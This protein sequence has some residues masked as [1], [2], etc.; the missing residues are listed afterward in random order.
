MPPPQT[1]II[2]TLDRQTQGWL[3]GLAVYEHPFGPEIHIICII[4]TSR[5]G[6]QGKQT[7]GM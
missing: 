3:K 1:V 7:G 6:C 4:M 2:A 5:Y